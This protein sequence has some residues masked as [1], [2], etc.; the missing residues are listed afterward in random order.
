MGF[1]ASLQGQQQ[2]HFNPGEGAVAPNYNFPPELGIPQMPPQPKLM[3]TSRKTVTFKGDVQTIQC[4]PPEENGYR[5]WGKQQPP[6]YEKG[7]S[8]MPRQPKLMTAGG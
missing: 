6:P 2:Q 8:Q 4:S 5:E 1:V 3:T 7:I